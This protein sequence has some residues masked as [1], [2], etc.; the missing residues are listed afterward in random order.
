MTA[1]SQ[2]IKIHYVPCIDT[3]VQCVFANGE[4]VKVLSCQLHND[5]LKALD[6]QG[7]S[8]EYDCFAER[9]HWHNV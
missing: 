4:M 1:V 9:R 3:T 6:L 7:F 2:S 8:C 5:L